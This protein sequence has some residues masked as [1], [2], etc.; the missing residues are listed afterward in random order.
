MVIASTKSVIRLTL[1]SGL[2]ELLHLMLRRSNH[3]VLVFEVTPFASACGT[4]IKGISCSIAIH[5][6]THMSLIDASFGKLVGRS[7]I[8]ARAIDVSQWDVKTL[9]VL[10]LTSDEPLCHLL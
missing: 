8:F 5:T 10:T 7:S 3:N 1:E 6:D 2:C 9:A 4:A